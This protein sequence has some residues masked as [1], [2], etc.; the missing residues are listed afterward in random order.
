MGSDL[1]QSEPKAIK[2]E[3]AL[4]SW[5]STGPNFNNEDQWTTSMVVPTD[6]ADRAL[7]SVT[8]RPK[9]MWNDLSA[10]N[11]HSASLPKKLNPPPGFEN[12]EIVHSVFEPQ[13]GRGKNTNNA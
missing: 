5:M 1:V 2:T 3:G 10:P 11:S 4:P 7:F 13:W 6:L 9:Q 8:D 12:L